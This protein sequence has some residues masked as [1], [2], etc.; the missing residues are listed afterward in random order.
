MCVCVCVCVCQFDMT[1]TDGNRTR[2][3]V[4]EAQGSYDAATGDGQKL[5]IRIQL[6]ALTQN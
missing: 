6:I 3:P 2:N 5:D 1:V 4:S